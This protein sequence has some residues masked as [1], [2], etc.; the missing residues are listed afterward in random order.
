MITGTYFNTF[1]F[2]GTLLNAQPTDHHW[3][4]KEPIGTDGNGIAIYPAVREYEITWDFLDT[5][6]WNQIY[7]FFLAQGVTGTIVSSL[8]Q[9]NTTPYTFYAYSGTVLR[10]PHYDNWF[11]NYYVNVKLIIVKILT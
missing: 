9:W 5:E 6:E 2:N 10:E 3:I 7:N 11:Q 4:E 1:S 8:P